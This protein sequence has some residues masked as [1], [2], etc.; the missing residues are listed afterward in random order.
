MSSELSS[1]L[2]LFIIYT[3]LLKPKKQRLKLNHNQIKIQIDLGVTNETRGTAFV[4]YEDIFEAKAALEAL[5]GFMVNGRYLVVLYYQREKSEKR[6]E[7][8]KERKKVAKLRE[9][10]IERQIEEEKKVQK[11]KLEEE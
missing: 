11:Q 10:I 6:K 9:Q 8:E 5:S 1:I 3:N 2:H 4:I 7:T